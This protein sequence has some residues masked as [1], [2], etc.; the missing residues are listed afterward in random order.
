M[1]ATV[2]FLMY[3]ILFNDLTE[4]GER[5]GKG[6]TIQRSNLKHRL[7]AALKGQNIRSKQ[8]P[9]LYDASLSYG[10]KC[11]DVGI[12]RHPDMSIIRQSKFFKIED[13]AR[14]IKQCCFACAYSRL[15][16]QGLF[17]TYTK[18]CRLYNKYYDFS[19]MSPRV[20]NGQTYSSYV[21]QK[22]NVMESISVRKNDRENKV[23]FSSGNSQLEKKRGEL[24]L[25]LPRVIDAFTFNHE[26]DLLE[27]RLNELKS[28]VAVH[29]LVESEHTTY[30][31][32]KPLHY[33]IHKD[34]ERFVDFKNKIIHIKTS[35]KRNLYGCKL[36]FLH[37]SDMRESIW[38]GL[39][40]VSIKY[41]R[42]SQ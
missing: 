4:V 30:G 2:I 25:N 13:K 32:P 19:D 3:T 26:L 31:D 35:N 17:D 11:I 8:E 33:D 14:S 21:L 41:L 28:E 16:Y 37:L 7:H 34:D 23:T 12:R 27:I 42:F 5:L 36:G 40:R 9:S 29:V 6:I 10:K 38:H 15:C 24:S 39:S 22:E 1:I 20:I 18:T